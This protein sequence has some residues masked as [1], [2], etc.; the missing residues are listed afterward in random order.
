[1]EGNSLLVGEAGLRAGGLASLD[2]NRKLKRC[3]QIL[4]VWNENSR[5]YGARKIW[6][7]L[8]R[9]GFKVTRCT[10]E[11]VIRRLGI[12]GVVRGKGY[13]T[14]VPDFVADRPADLALAVQTCPWCVRDQTNRREIG[15]PLNESDC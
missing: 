15:C 5:V 1:M 10:V 14:T 8:R 7:Q 2:E 11:R 9:E 12:R 3:N 6:R 13:K 4:R